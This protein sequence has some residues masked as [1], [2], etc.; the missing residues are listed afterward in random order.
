MGESCKGEDWSAT[1]VPGELGGAIEA[2]ICWATEMM[3]LMGFP[4]VDPLPAEPLR[5]PHPAERWLG[6]AWTGRRREA[7]ANRLGQVV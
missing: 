3:F 2:M 7:L 5:E 1:N 4:M 6:Q